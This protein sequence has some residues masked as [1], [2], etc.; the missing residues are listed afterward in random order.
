MAFVNDFKDPDMSWALR[1]VYVCTI[2]E[3]N[4]AEFIADLPAI[5]PLIRS[6]HNKAVAMITQG[7]LGTSNKGSHGQ[8]SVLTIGS[9]HKR[10]HDVKRGR[11]AQYGDNGQF[12]TICDESDQE[13]PLRD[14]PRR[15]SVVAKG[16]GGGITVQVNI[17]MESQE[18]SH[19]GPVW[20]KGSLRP[21][22]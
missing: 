9:A 17:D 16:N 7:S 18:R 12:T 1:R 8:S 21:E 20:P 6:M 14:E 4:F 3:R 10:L 13:I 22:H 19:N 2:V 15:G 5:F 11:F